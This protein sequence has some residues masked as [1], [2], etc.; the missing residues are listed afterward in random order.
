M[1]CWLPPPQTSRQLR[2]RCRFFFAHYL[3]VWLVMNI[4]P[5]M[6]HLI[7]RI[8]LSINL[9]DNA[10][11]VYSFLKKASFHGLAK[12]ISLRKNGLPDQLPAPPS[13][14]IFLVI[15]SVWA[16]EYWNSGLTIIDDLQTHLKSHSINADR[17]H[18]I[19]DFG[20]GCG[21]LT[22][23]LTRFKN[24]ELFGAD[25][26]RDLIDWS[27][28]TLP[29]AKFSQ[30]N[31]EPPISFSSEYFDLILA[32]SV[33]THLDYQLQYAWFQ[34]LHRI[35]QPRGFLYF[36]THSGLS[37]PGIGTDLNHRLNVGGFVS[38]NPE[39]QGDNK[40]SVY[41]TKEW[42]YHNL[43]NGF[44]IID[45]IPGRHVENLGQDIYIFQRST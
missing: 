33:F 10:R 24:A 18:R 23:H 27:S 32:R 19:L 5:N 12:E 39:L 9:L 8:L 22:R 30:N 37:T 15:R 38:Q 17:F 43:A 44:S 7:K 35:L 14:L 29:I 40:C 16:F 26:N 25:Y 45:Y 3:Q 28:K 13:N 11:L 2:R 1:N 20:C 31:L 6:K 34:E 21:R 42:V 4:F 41:Q 36:T